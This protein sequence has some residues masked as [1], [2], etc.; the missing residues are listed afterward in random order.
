MKQLYNENYIILI[1]EI[2][3]GTK[4]ER[5]PMLMNWKN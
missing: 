1:K 5:H 3:E 4:R 2:E